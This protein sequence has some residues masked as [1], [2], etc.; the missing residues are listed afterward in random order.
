[1]DYT[2][3]WDA[4]IPGYDH[5]PPRSPADFAAYGAAFASR[6]GTGG[7]FWRTHPTIPA[8][9]IATYEIWNEPDGPGFWLP[10]AQ[11]DRYADLYL[12]ARAA[13]TAEQPDARVIVGGLTQP[14]TFLPAMV[15][16]RPQLRGHVDGVAIHPYA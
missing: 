14:T 11:P 10:T 12:A 3:L 4:S 1:I 8:K 5:S 15:A 9:P 13:I 6:Y 7:T 2:T 16:A